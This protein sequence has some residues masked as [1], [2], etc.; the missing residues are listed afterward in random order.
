LGSVPVFSFVCRIDIWAQWEY[1]I[2]N[3]FRNAALF[4]LKE[5]MDDGSGYRDFDEG[6]AGGF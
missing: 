2:V 4:V 5:G 3:Y 1:N 6:R